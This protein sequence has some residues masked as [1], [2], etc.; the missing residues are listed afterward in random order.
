M[1]AVTEA[2]WG[3]VQPGS[4]VDRSVRASLV[5]ARRDLNPREPHS[6]SCSRSFDSIQLVAYPRSHVSAGKGQV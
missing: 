6:G 5:V 2:P 4:A 3:S 1:T